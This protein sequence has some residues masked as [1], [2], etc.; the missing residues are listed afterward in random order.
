[1]ELVDVARHLLHIPPSPLYDRQGRPMQYV[2]DARG[3]GTNI[4][5]RRWIVS[6]FAEMASE[7]EPSSIIGVANSGVVWAAW[8]AEYLSLPYA[9]VLPDGPRKSGLNRQIEGVP[10]AG[11]TILIDNWLVTG[12]SV[13]KSIAAVTQKSEAKVAALLLVAEPAQPLPVFEIPVRGVV[14]VTHLLQAIDRTD[15]LTLTNTQIGLT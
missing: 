14:A 15:L 7:Y 8:T 1:M 12:D 6:R 2:V 13:L 11:P 4:S 3:A 10:P 5:L 9:T